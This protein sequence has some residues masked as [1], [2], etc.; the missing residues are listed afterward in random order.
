MSADLSAGW[1]DVAEAFIALRS[2]AGAA[3]VKD[4]TK[5]LPAGASVVD[6]GCG[7]GLPITE[8]LVQAGC[9]VHAIDASPK[10]VA[11]FR[12]RFPQIEIACE[13]AEDSAF[14]GRTF[15]GA[16]A[17][18]LVF[19]LPVASQRRLIRRVGNALKP[20]GLFF[21]SAP[22]QA[23][24]WADSLTGQM[25]VS[26]GLDGYV[27]ALESTGFSVVGACLDEGENHHIQAVRQ[28]DPLD[29]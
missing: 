2:G 16:V 19:L 8:V 27:E 15:D 21:F 9:A 23:C 5:N 22:R 6:I 18:G 20:G 3:T 7:T 29:L 28:K 14:F 25:S 4:W 1:D 13:A 26:L 11:V 10:L 17:V 12:H 24:E